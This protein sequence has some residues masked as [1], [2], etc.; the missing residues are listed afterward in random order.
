[1]KCENL[2]SERINNLQFL[3]LLYFRTSDIFVIKCQLKYAEMSFADADVNGKVGNNTTNSIIHK[4]K[5][6][7]DDTIFMPQQHAFGS[8]GY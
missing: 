5:R 7:H 2:S 6:T 8:L 1:M 3:F 4:R